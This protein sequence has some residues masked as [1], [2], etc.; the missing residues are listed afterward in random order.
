[1]RI[2]IVADLICPWCFI[3]KRRLERAV[4]AR[5]EL[6]VSCSWRVFQL[7]PDMP[8]DGL[9]R[10]LYLRIKYGAGR[11]AMRVFAAIA[12]AGRG[13]GIAF[14]FDKIRRTPSTL[15]AHRLVRLAAAEGCADLVVEALFRGYF[16]DGLDIGD[17]DVLAMLADA[18][19]LDEMTSRAY[20]AGDAGA[21]ETRAEEQRVRRLG[22][23]AVPC[24]IFDHG[25]AIS[26][27][28]EP[29]MFLPLFD[30]A[31]A[32]RQSPVKA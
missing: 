21:A 6:A 14:D 12:E 1:M 7:N 20:L 2:D 5:S 11:T 28:Q 29:E 30:L 24:F 16:E 17:I 18:A 31:T 13:E 9:P 27:A 22:V 25:Y 3:G 15:R 4:A 19:G 10:D 23:N 32:V 8:A 26:G